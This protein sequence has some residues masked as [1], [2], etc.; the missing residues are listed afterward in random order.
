MSIIRVTKRENPFVMIEKSAIEDAR[1]SWRARGLLVYFL[2]KPDAWVIRMGHIA[3]QSGGGRDALRSAMRELKEAGYAAL[4]NTSAGSEWVIRERPETMPPPENPHAAFAKAA[5]TPPSNKES[6]RKKDKRV[7]PN[8]IGQQAELLPAIPAS[9][10]LDV[11]VAWNEQAHKLK[12]IREVTAS[13]RDKIR[14]RVN[15]PFFR[16][17]YRAAIAR[18]AAS[19]FCTG[20]NR[21]GWTADFDWFVNNDKN[22]AKVMEGKYDNAESPQ[23]TRPRA[24]SE[25]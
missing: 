18:I 25:Y 6:E 7:M 12:A 19:D 23:R 15:E 5:K 4:I 11:A 1:L 2:S 21:T 20:K 14:A 22:I 24:E 9:V 13:R 17:N 16:A 8:G 3:E 10:G